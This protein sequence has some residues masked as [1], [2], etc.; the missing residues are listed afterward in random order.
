MGRLHSGILLF[1]LVGI[2]SADI[3][4]VQKCS[5]HWEATWFEDTGIHKDKV[6]DL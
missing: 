1:C 2:L 6:W 4:M 3:G 5:L